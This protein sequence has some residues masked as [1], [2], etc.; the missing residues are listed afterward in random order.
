MFYT[1]KPTKIIGDPFSSYHTGE[2]FCVGFYPTLG[3]DFKLKIAPESEHIF[4]P[5]EPFSCLIYKARYTI[6]LPGL[7]GLEPE[8]FNFSKN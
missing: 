7:W 2:E 4:E 5:K 8:Y 3:K 6:F 1:E